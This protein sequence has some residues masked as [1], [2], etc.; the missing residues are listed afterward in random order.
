MAEQKPDDGET[1]LVDLDGVV[2]LAD[3]PIPG[4]RDALARL[5]DSGRRVAY[6]TNNSFSTRT[7]MLDKFADHGISLEPDDLL[8]SAD[9]AVGLVRPDERA[10]VLGGHGID[11][12]LAAK[13]IATVALEELSAT[14]TV[15]VVIVG[16][17]RRVNF[18]R[19]AAA[20]RAVDGGA[21]LIGTND[22]ATYPTPDGHLPGGGSLLA[23]VAYATSVTPV[24]AGKPYQ[25]AVDLVTARLGPVAVM[26]GDRP[27][28]DGALARGLA[29]RYALVRSGVTPAGESVSPTPDYDASD[30]AALVEQVLG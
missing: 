27:S 17:D 2:W 9:A 18:D 10:A 7:Q 8:S 28:T 4:S 25:P 21:R 13:G 23:A 16:L 6:F 22:D 24:V 26:V 5:R 14:V 19:L 29:A 3:R 20:C 30:L 12:A 11:E 15:D 1:W